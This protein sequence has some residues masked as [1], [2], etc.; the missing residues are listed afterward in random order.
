MEVGEIGAV[1]S[2]KSMH[3]QDKLLGVQGNNINEKK[4]SKCGSCQMDDH[5]PNIYLSSQFCLI[6]GYFQYTH[7]TLFR[8]EAVTDGS[9]F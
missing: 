7:K 4:K 8:D 2:P 6:E 1:T 3:R 9:N 5:S